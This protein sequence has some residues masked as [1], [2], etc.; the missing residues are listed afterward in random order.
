M[1]VLGKH[2]MPQTVL[3]STEHWVWFSLESFFKLYNLIH[4]IIILYTSV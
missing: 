2:I 3:N 1:K 4:L